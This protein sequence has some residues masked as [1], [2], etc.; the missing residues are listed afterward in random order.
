[1]K[2]R[3]LD[4]H[5]VH[6]ERILAIDPHRIVSTSGRLMV[7]KKKRPDLPSTKM[8]QT[9]FCNDVITGQP[10]GFTLSASGNTYLQAT[11]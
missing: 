8:M 6:G 10:L 1:M 3:V 11:L 4:G 5:Y 2:I 9:F 7:Q